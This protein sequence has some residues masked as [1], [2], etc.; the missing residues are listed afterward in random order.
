MKE[1][2]YFSHD[3]NARHDPKI[4]AMRSVFG[5]K[6]YGWYWIII[7][8]MREEQNYMIK[9]S[10]YL[11]N[12][13]SMQLGCEIDEAEEFVLACIQEFELFVDDNEYIWSSSLLRRMEVKESKQTARKNRAQKAAKARWNSSQNKQNNHQK[14]SSI[15]EKDMLSMHE[16]STSNIPENANVMLEHCLDMPKKEK[17][18]KVKESKVNKNKEEKDSMLPTK[19]SNDD[20]SDVVSIAETDK[21]A[22]AY[23]QQCLDLAKL[24]R[25]KILERNPSFKLPADKELGKWAKSIDYMIRLDK[26]DP[27]Q[28]RQIILFSQWNHFWKKN[29]RSTAKLRIQFDRLVDEKSDYDQKRASPSGRYNN[30][31]IPIGRV[32]L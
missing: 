2:Y 7:E 29:I 13:L 31:K 11:W 3:S 30:S 5:A 19:V 10:K 1:A 27:E 28:I 16:H 6:G 14:S 8:M 21:E 18:I 15:A 4:L 26:R 12:I 24:L 25:D 23:K 22:Q 9:K 32:S 17:E 20:Q